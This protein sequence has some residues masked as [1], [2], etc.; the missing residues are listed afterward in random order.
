MNARIRVETEAKLAVQQAIKDGKIE[1]AWSYILDYENSANP[2]SER[3]KTIAQW[4]EFSIIDTEEH[5][6]ILKIAAGL[7]KK[8][9][10]NLDALHIAAAVHTRCEYFI[11]TDDGIL[12]KAK[13]VTTITILDPSEFVRKVNL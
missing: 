5:P 2:Y 1:L 3:R 7:N 6:S 4:R 10:S 11:T 9:V 12:N 13:T 8:G